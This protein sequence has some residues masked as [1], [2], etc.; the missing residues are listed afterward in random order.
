M[1][2]SVS[3]KA[4][5]SILSQRGDLVDGRP[6][7][8]EPSYPQLISKKVFLKPVFLKST[9]TQICQLVFTDAQVDGF[10]CE[11][12]L[13]KRGLRHF[14]TDKN[15]QP[16]SETLTPRGPARSIKGSHIVDGTVSGSLSPTLALTLTHTRSVSHPHS[17]SHTLSRS[18]Q[19]GEGAGLVV[20]L[21]RLDQPSFDRR[22]FP[23]TSNKKMVRCIPPMN[24]PVKVTKMQTNM[25]MVTVTNFVT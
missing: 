2:D 10:I 7:L 15:A 24:Q 25:N 18:A 19:G 23:S 12:S 11:L 6:R 13:A 3:L 4:M 17:L 20:A 5:R 8:D 1:V 16:Q 21:P 9:P 14:L 22:R